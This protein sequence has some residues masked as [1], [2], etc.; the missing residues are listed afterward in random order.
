MLEKVVTRLANFRRAG[1]SGMENTGTVFAIIGVEQT[2]CLESLP[3]VL[4]GAPIF[5]RMIIAGRQ[6]V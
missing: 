6:L 2:V 5:I 1:R 3:C 4:R